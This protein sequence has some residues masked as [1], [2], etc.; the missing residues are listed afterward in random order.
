MSA[1]RYALLDGIRGI[2]A[3]FVLTRHTEA[4]WGF[5]LP[6]SYL[7]VDLFFLLSGFVIRAAYHERL[8]SGSIDARQFVLLRLIRL[9]PVY[10]FSVLVALVCHGLA[11]DLVPDAGLALSTLLTLLFLPSVLGTAA[12]LF[13]LNG[14]YWSLLFELIVNL[15]YG[16]VWRWLSIRYLIILSAGLLAFLTVVGT[17]AG[18]LNIGFNWGGQS[19]LVGLAR[20]TYGIATGMLLQHLSSHGALTPRPWLGGVATCA[21]LLMPDLGRFDFWVDILAVGFI[22]PLG[23]LMMATRRPTRVDGVLI[24]LGAASYPTYVL[25]EPLGR[26]LDWALPEA[27]ANHA[28]LSG[29]L[30]VFLLVPVMALIERRAD[31]PLRRW[32]NARWVYR[33]RSISVTPGQPATP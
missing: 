13:P 5:S 1:S 28:P 15:G 24:L 29:L 22:L 23:I 32:L 9:Y 17:L 3:L 33:R 16:A 10:F 2:A 14:P 11:G 31:E 6:H 30:F 27:L 4:M 7:A 18:H 8:A 26:L 19:M 25:H 21:V 12:Y 20:A